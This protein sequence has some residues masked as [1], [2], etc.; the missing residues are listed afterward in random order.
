MSSIV[1]QFVVLSFVVTGVYIVLTHYTGAEGVTG[2][3]GKADSE[4]FKTL[5]GIPQ[6]GTSA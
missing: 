5:Q 2:A 3:L 1:K 6:H 4:I